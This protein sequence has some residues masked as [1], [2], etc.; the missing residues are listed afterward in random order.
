MYLLTSR[1]YC[2]KKLVIS[3]DLTNPESAPV[4]YL[5]V[6]IQLTKLHN[7]ISFYKG[8]L[9]ILVSKD[10]LILI[11]SGTLLQ[12]LGVILLIQFQLHI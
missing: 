1:D 8:I 7:A 3:T 11:V 9:H 2:K 12:I 10:E 4:M 5:K 6:L